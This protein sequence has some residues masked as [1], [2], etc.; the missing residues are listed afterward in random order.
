MTADLARALISS[1]VK[2][3]IRCFVSLFFK[4]RSRNLST[5]SCLRLP[6][7]AGTDELPNDLATKIL[8]D[9]ILVDEI[10]VDK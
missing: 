7:T 9:V 2:I 4:A 5:K 3:F 6:T 10:L 8:V 1:S